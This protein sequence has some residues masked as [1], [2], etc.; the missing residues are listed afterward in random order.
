MYVIAIQH[1]KTGVSI[2]HTETTTTSVKKLVEIVEAEMPRSIA[3]TDST[4][5]FT[6]P[7]SHAAYK[8]RQ[9]NNEA[10]APSFQDKLVVI[11]GA[12]SGSGR[13]TAKLLASRGALLSLSDI[14]TAGLEAVKA[15]LKRC[16]TT[17][18]IVNVYARKECR[19]DSFVLG[20]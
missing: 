2:Y 14:N 6:F 1:S 16:H 17:T 11:S 15:E 4:P 7:F 12:A 9:T 13:A 8:T 3:L 19:F 10:M 20:R 18:T 5:F